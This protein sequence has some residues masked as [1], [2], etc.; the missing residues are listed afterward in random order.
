MADLQFGGFLHLFDDPTHHSW[1]KSHIGLIQNTEILATLAELP[2]IKAICQLTLP[3]LV[4]R[5]RAI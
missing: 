3:H 4:E 2:I 5:A 1:A